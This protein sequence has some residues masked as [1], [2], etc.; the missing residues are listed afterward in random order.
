MTDHHVSIIIPMYDRWELTHQLLFDILHHCNVDCLHEV[1]IANNGSSNEFVPNGIKWW[2]SLGKLPIK[3]FK[4]DENV[5]FIRI[6]NFAVSK[7]KGDIII[8]ISNDVRVQTDIVTR[9]V[10]ILEDGKNIV[11]GVLY[12]ND[13]GWN[14]FRGKI[15]PYLEGWLL[16]F[17]KEAWDEIGGFDERY[18]PND[19]EDVDFSTVASV[20]DYNLVPLNAGTKVW[21]IGAQTIH[22]GPEREALTKRNKEKFRR[23]WVK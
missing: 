19:F 8:L 9:I 1:I 18:V 13:T 7:A 23:K 2:K 16:G 3:E 17:S 4:A 5:G 22:Y 15:Y 21:H 14:T 20:L 6:C 12:E 11:G 10:Q